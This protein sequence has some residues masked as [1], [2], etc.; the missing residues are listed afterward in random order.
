MLTDTRPAPSQVIM[1][2]MQT[3]FAGMASA[4]NAPVVPAR[5][6]TR[7]APVQMAFVDSLCATA[8]RGPLPCLFEPVLGP[9]FSRGTSSRGLA[10]PSPAY[11]GLVIWLDIRPLPPR[12][13]CSS[14]AHSSS[15]ASPTRVP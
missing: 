2:S 1:L 7:V 14:L 13:S 15:F 12:P 4:F 10:P 8:L 3:T 9:G 6:A 11:S 5:M